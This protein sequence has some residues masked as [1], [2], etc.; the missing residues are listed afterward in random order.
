MTHMTLLPLNKSHATMTQ[1][2][3]QPF[4]MAH[5]PSVAKYWTIVQ[6]LLLAFTIF[7]VLEGPIHRGE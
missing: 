6:C 7:E 5:Y 3:P 2:L 4:N 1:T